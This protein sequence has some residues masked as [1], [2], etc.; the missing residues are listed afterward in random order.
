[1]SK[2]IYV[3]QGCYAVLSN[4]NDQ[5]RNII[6]L[7]TSGVGP[8]C[9]IIIANSRTGIMFL[10][11][12]DSLTNLEDEHH[13]VL[14]WVRR[15]CPSGDYENLIIDIGENATHT[16]NGGEIAHYLER[17][18]RCLNVLRGES[19]QA[20]FTITSHCAE[21]PVYG[22]SI[23]NLNGHLVISEEIQHPS[24]L[25]EEWREKGIQD[26]EFIQLR[27][28]EQR[29]LESGIVKAREYAHDR[30]N[31]LNQDDDYQEGRTAGEDTSRSG[32]LVLVFPPI[33]IFDGSSDQY[34]SL[35][36][37]AHDC[38]RYG[39]EWNR[40]M[41]LDA[42][43]SYAG[44]DRDSKSSRAY[45]SEFEKYSDDSAT[46]K[47]SHSDPNEIKED[48]ALVAKEYEIQFNQLSSPQGLRVVNVPGDGNCFFH[49]LKK[50][51]P[52]IG[53]THEEI[54]A[55]AVNY[56]ANN[57]NEFEGF[58]VETLDDYI[59]GMSQGG[60]WANNPIMQALVNALGIG[61]D[62][63]R[64][65]GVITTLVPTNGAA[66]ATATIAY[67][68]IHY[69]SVEPIQPQDGVEE[70]IPELLEGVSTGVGCSSSSSTLKPSVKPTG[71]PTSESTVAISFIELGFIAPEDHNSTS[72]DTRLL[73]SS[74]DAEITPDIS[75]LG[76]TSSTDS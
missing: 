57:P 74:P 40:V 69:L 14:S 36:Q 21:R 52:N 61:I 23:L 31:K 41:D 66:Q 19:P 42:T 22:V 73:Q 24:Q 35:D 38:E 62:I 39:I 25:E 44:S 16:R 48:L 33:C 64:A 70:E 47:S 9:H 37:I 46:R 11:H 71:A 32:I 10:C 51:L 54:R 34:R 12:A 75:Y 29:V 1:M 13:G 60:T 26:R 49:A 28:E 4:I 67:T 8:C 3:A 59:A 20:R 53:I 56:M 76:V 72:S 63:H 7:V 6:G 58:T 45:S 15:A 27:D 65:N 17:V 50:Q 68:G 43:S 30:H 18:N 5:N 2:I 55:L